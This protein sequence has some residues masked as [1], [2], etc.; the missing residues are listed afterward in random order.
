MDKEEKINH[1][2]CMSRYDIESAEYMLSAGRYVYVVFMC[3]QAIEKVMKALFIKVYDEEPIRT[4]NV[5]FLFHKINEEGTFSKEIIKE[6]NEIWE[7]YFVEILSFYTEVRYVDYKVK[8]E[9]IVDAE[10][11]HRVFEKGKEAI[12]WIQKL[13]NL[14]ST[15][16]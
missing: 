8:I 7:E 16:S 11:A 4:H 9:D 3:Q 14:K 2:L 12:I 6:Y 10:H 5:N 13:L 1:W 15:G